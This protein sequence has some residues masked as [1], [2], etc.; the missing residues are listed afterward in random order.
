MSSAKWNLN[1]HVASV[2]EGSKPFKCNICD[3][4]YSRTQDLNRHVSLVHEGKKPFQCG[5][6]SFS[7]SHKA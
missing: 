5:M 1:E 3:F 4:N 6:C 7:C 2:H